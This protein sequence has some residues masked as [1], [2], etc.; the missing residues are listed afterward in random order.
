MKLTELLNEAEEIQQRLDELAIN[1]GWRD[2]GEQLTW[3]IL[4]TLLRAALDQAS[5]KETK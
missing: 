4:T 3:K 2:R 5:S 1:R